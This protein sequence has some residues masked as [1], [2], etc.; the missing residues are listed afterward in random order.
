LQLAGIGQVPLAGRSLA[1]ANDDRRWR[2]AA[3]MPPPP[4]RGFLAIALF[5]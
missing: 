3:D 1:L 5:T 2:I 4:G